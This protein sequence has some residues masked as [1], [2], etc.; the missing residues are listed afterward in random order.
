M[1][2]LVDRWFG[3]VISVGL[4]LAILLGL[5][6][7]TVEY[8]VSPGA[9]GSRFIC[10]IEDTRLDYPRIPEERDFFANA[11]PLGKDSVMP[12]DDLIGGEGL[13]GV[14]YLGWAEQ[15]RGCDECIICRGLRPCDDP[16][17]YW[18][19]LMLLERPEPLTGYALRKRSLEENGAESSRL[20]NLHRS[21][22]RPGSTGSRAPSRRP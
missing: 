13:P 1:S 21:S 18:I 12:F 14:G 3:T 19:R 20:N 15:D 5:A 16:C 22:L 2:R 9:G 4:H 10:S 11:K 17:P 6:F 7:A 8:L